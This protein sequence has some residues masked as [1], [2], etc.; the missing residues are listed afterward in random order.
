VTCTLT[1]AEH[2][3]TWK[4][5]RDDCTGA[6][7]CGFAIRDN[8]QCNRGHP[9]DGITWCGACGHFDP[10]GHAAMERR[11]AETASQ[12]ERTTGGNA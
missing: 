5:W 9:D 10:A 11:I 6:D 7:G 8:D 3:A 12:H 1:H 4:S 2:A